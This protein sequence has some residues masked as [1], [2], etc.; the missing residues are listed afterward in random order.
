LALAFRGLDRA[1][2]SG[3]AA[4]REAASSVKD[5]SQHTLLMPARIFL[6][7][8]AFRLATFMA[9]LPKHIHRWLSGVMEVT[10]S[11]QQLR[12]SLQT[13]MGDVQE[14]EKHFADL[15][16]VA[17]LPGINTEQALR[18]SLAMQ[19]VGYSANFAAR[20]AAVWS[21]ALA[22]AGRSAEELPYVSLALTQM[23]QASYNYGQEMRQLRE[24]IPQFARA[25]NELYGT[26][27]SQ[28][29]IKMGITGR[30]MV[31]EV[32]NWLEKLAKA[33]WT[34]ETSME[35]LTDAYS[36]FREAV[37]RPLITPWA[38]FLQQIA[39]V[40]DYIR[41]ASGL[42]ER[43]MAAVK[44]GM[45]LWKGE[46]VGGSPAQRLVGQVL[47]LV[48]LLRGPSILGNLGT[49]IDYA[50]I[51]LAIIE[52]AISRIPDLFVWIGK[53]V[54][55]A[56]PPLIAIINY[57]TQTLV[58]WFKTFANIMSIVGGTFL[59]YMIGSRQVLAEIVGIITRVGD[60]LLSIAEKFDM[61]WFPFF[62]KFR[63]AWGPTIED[64]K[65]ATSRET[66]S[67]GWDIVNRLLT[68]EGRIFKDV[69]PLGKPLVPPKPG[70]FIPNWL[71][72]SIGLDSADVM[73]WRK[74]IVGALKGGAKIKYGPEKGWESNLGNISRSSAATAR[75]T[76]H[77]ADSMDWTIRGFGVSGIEGY[78]PTSVEL[79]QLRQGQRQINVTVAGAKT[80]EQMLSDMIAQ[81]VAQVH[82][83]SA[84]AR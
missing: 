41:T 52:K 13:T 17:K 46:Q 29:L 42:I 9:D 81:T 64:L 1:A 83:Q 79:A 80:F 5:W 56:V 36:R 43:F 82:V 10:G 65:K 40:L 76:Q 60:M 4:I 62:G 24:R 23:G 67:Y 21:N 66:L 49:W 69:G 72:R 74:R 63:E 45:D 70:E 71:S 25:L 33:P 2:T 18:W 61:P 51:F 38:N 27:L 30:Q 55:K 44:R 78:L 59:I 54:D 26:S 58:P 48:R 68:S 50:A 53:A 22:R 15:Q 11:Y 73:K 75:N 28:D 3:G 12:L 47:S 57:V 7:L 39:N 32:T 8:E 19:A 16:E 6:I 20:S 77:I 34:V 31:V 84:F 14:A 35:N 37:G